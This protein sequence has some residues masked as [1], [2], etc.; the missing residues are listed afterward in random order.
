[1]ADVSGSVEELVNQS[2]PFVRAGVVEEVDGFGIGGDAADDREVG[3]AEEGGVIGP[4]SGIEPALCP[5]L[6]KQLVNLSGCLPVGLTFLN[7]GNL[8]RC[9]AL[10]PGDAQAA[11]FF[12]V[13][14]KAAVFFCEVTE[15]QGKGARFSGAAKG[16]FLL[17]DGEQL[18]IHRT[19]RDIGVDAGIQ[20][21]GK[22][23][24]EKEGES[25]K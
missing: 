10:V 2:D 15:G 8:R 16:D 18:G 12:L 6:L 11:G 9:D 17:K 13:Q 20:L 7:R 22:T 23:K 4:R 5:V 19:A 3:A 21:R 25:L 24:Y 14:D 1:M